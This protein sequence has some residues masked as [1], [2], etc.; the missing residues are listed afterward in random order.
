MFKKLFLSSLLYS[1]AVFG[2]SPAI[3]SDK[4]YFTNDEIC[5]T[6]FDSFYIH[7][8][9]NV[10]LKTDCIYRDAGG[11]YFY[12]NGDPKQWKCPYCYMFFPVGKRCNNSDCASKFE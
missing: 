5:E 8:G 4:L 1:A 3:D 11:R 10:W 2:V 12:T 7:T 9:E 6:Y